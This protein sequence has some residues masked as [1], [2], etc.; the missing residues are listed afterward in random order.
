MTNDKQSAQPPKSEE[1]PIC[2]IVMPISAIDDCSIVHWEDV[3]KILCD[4]IAAAGYVPN[5]V[6]DADDSGVIQ[7]RI[8]QNL[9]S[10]EIVICDVS[11]KNP[12][13]MF[14]LGMRL[15]F[16]K[17]TIIVM[18]DRTNYSFD[19]GIVE[20]LSYP[21][22]LNYFKILNFQN[23][24]KNKILGTIEN[25]RQP[26]YTT[27]LKNF[28]EFKVAAI[29]QKEGSINDLIL[30]R[31]DDMSRQIN[32]IKNNMTILQKRSNIDELDKEHRD[33]EQSLIDS[34]ILNKTGKISD[35]YMQNYYRILR[36]ISDSSDEK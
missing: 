18:D 19:T 27:F 28:G 14:E 5:L 21:R 30:S 24:L 17:P 11:C 32:V 1:K 4:A 23:T 12:N 20:H 10:N 6:S 25:A 13:V 26:E 16:D 3:K 29:K 31:L 15:A 35:D 7:K 34:S 22:D 36:K 33:I 9:Y 8:V 2:G